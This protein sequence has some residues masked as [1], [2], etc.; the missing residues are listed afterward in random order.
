MAMSKDEKK[1]MKALRKR[2]IDAETVNEEL[3]A[4]N[5]EASIQLNRAELDKDSAVEEAVLTERQKMEQTIRDARSGTTRKDMIVD[6]NRPPKFNPNA[7]FSECFGGDAVY[8]QAGWFFD[9]KRRPLRPTNPIKPSSV[10]QMEP[11][12]PDEKEK[13]H[14]PIIDKS[15]ATA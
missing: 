9:N 14:A 15:L 4:A 8:A 12:A 10:R 2:A 3:T 5:T 6:P 11:T 1:E 13:D 7:Y